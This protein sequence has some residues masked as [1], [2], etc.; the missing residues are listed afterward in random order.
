MCIFFFISNK[1]AKSGEIFVSDKPVKISAY[2]TS[3]YRKG[4]KL[5][6]LFK[7]R[8]S[9]TAQYCLICVLIRLMNLFLFC[10]EKAIFLKILS[11]FQ[12]EQNKQIKLKFK[13][14]FMMY[15]NC[16]DDPNVKCR[17]Y[18][19]TRYYHNLANPGARY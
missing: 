9:L 19:E 13:G 1:S 10:F 4:T 3:D 7:V 16:T 8:L 15:Y 2:A 6:W 14:D 11:F 12:T 5:S 18:V 17:D